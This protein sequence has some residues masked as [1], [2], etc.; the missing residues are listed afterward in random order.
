MED[1]CHSEDVNSY[2]SFEKGF[3]HL[4][5]GD[6]LEKHYMVKYLKDEHSV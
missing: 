3:A 2:K 1:I 5:A 6:D 4:K